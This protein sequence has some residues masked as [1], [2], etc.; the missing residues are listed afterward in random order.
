VGT[1]MAIRMATMAI[2]TISSIN[3]NPF[4]SRPIVEAS[5]ER[6]IP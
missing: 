5:A 1:A 4:S 3:V 2:T 6:P